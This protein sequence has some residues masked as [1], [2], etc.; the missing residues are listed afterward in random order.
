MQEQRGHLITGD[1]VQL[2]R[3][4]RLLNRL[5]DQQDDLRREFDGCCET[6]QPDELAEVHRLAAELREASRTN[7]LLAC[8]GAQY[9]EFSL[10]LVA[11][12]DEQPEQGEGSLHAVNEFS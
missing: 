9:A 5:L 6:F 10:S 7:Y 4:N 11:A 12:A 3:T 8:R 2:Q 1:L